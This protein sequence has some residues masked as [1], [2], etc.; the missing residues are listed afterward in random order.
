MQSSRRRF[1]VRCRE[2]SRGADPTPGPNWV[3]LV[4]ITPLTSTYRARL[5][6]KTRKLAMAHVA[7]C[8]EP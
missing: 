2:G 8:G 3:V 7:T 1:I 4:G 6:D 5:V